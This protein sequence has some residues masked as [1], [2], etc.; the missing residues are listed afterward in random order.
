VGRVRWLKPHFIFIC[1]WFG[2]KVYRRGRRFCVGVVR[3]EMASLGRYCVCNGANQPP[4]HTYS[5][6]YPANELFNRDAMFSIAVS[7][8]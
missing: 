8:I 3:F 4:Y 6:Y 2:F 1:A 5:R 7:L